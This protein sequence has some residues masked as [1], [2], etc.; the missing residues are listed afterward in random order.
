MS[1]APGSE[2]TEIDKGHGRIE[3][4]TVR[5]TRILTADGWPGLKLGIEIRRERTVKGQTTVEGEYAITSYSTDAATLLKMIRDHWRIENSLHWVRDVTLGEDAC[6]VRTGNAPQV[7]AS[8]RNAVVYLLSK[9]KAESRV[10]AI[11][12]LQ[13]RPE[14][15]KTLIGLK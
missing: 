12:R 10:A 2:A 1:L 3:K 7:L 9:V 15:A 13:A 11:E 5:T 8:L 6:R 4:R 14:E